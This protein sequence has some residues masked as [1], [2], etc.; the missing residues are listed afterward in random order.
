MACAKISAAYPGI[1]IKN[2][3]AMKPEELMEANDLSAILGQKRN[4]YGATAG[5]FCKSVSCYI[6]SS[7]I[8]TSNE[9]FAYWPFVRLVKIY[10]KSR[11]LEH[12]LVLVDLPGLGDSNAGRAHV[13]ESYIKNLRFIWVVADIVRAINDKVAHDLMGSSFRRQLLMD[14]KYDDSYVT[15][16]MTK[17]D[18]IAVQEVMNSLNLGAAVLANEVET[19]S[20]LQISLEEAKDQLAE[21]KRRVSESMDSLKTYQGNPGPDTALTRKRKQPESDTAMTADA[22]LIS[23]SLMTDAIFLAQDELEIIRTEALQAQKELQKTI[24]QLRKTLKGVQLSMKIACIRERNLYTQQHLQ[25]E[26]Q[27]GIN[28]L[29]QELRETIGAPNGETLNTRGD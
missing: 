26:F 28:Q 16:I 4:I 19:E 29:Q 20:Q 9:R 7:N 22:E 11:V 15:F 2:I 8:G 13:A 17:T 1:D 3:V 23:D 12:G 6:D 18:Q 14:G 21:A 25:L 5:E 10:V 27:D 24:S